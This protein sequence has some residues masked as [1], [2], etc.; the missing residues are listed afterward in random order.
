M[1]EDNTLVLVAEYA[2]A[3]EAEMAKSLLG[4]A[5]IEAMIG[6]EYMSTS[7]PMAIPARIFVREEDAE[8]AREILKR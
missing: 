6:D 3:T 4:N 2:S 8:R 7:Y 1:K 5:E